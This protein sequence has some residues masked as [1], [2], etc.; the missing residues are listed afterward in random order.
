MKKADI[1]RNKVLRSL[2]DE[3]ITNIEP[4]SSRL[5]CENYIPEAS[6]ATLRIDLHKLEEQNYIYQPHTSAGRVPTIA[7]YRKYLEDIAKEIAE[8]EYARTDFLRELLIKNY[9]DTPLALHYI[10]QML[11]RETDQLSFVAEPEMA[12][13][14]LEKLDV[15]KIGKDKL[16]WV[17]S[18]DSG[19]DKTVILKTDYDISEQQLR[20]LVRYVNEE[21]YGLRIYDIQNKYLEKI[22]DK[23]SDE[24]RLLSLF[25]EELRNA[26]SEIGSYFIHFE[27][28][29]EFLKQ[30]E[31]DEKEIV[32][33]FL[34]LMQRQDL[35]VNLIQQAYERSKAEK[36][37][38][39]VV[40][41]EE[42]G[43]AQW[44]DFVLIFTKYELFGVPGYLGTLSPVRMNYRKNIPI[45]RDIA[46]TITQTTKKGMM[47]P[48]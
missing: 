23:A 34:G 2:I 39:F 48:K 42:F 47:I 37:D 44:S 13:G 18:L 36:K 27:G 21:L 17:V 35:I 19:M 32:L 26:L 14:Y 6:S 15:F 31:F 4:V 38:Y 1:R 9:K 30:P 46:E 40:M 16:L 20:V 22:S 7:G 43:Q 3:Y 5:L 11:A 33:S 24:N 41:G 25:L 29:I 12:F 45:I 28:S 10:K 8:A